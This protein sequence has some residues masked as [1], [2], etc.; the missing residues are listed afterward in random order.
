MSRIFLVCCLAVSLF[1]LTASAGEWTG[2][3]S[4]SHCGAKHMDGSDAAAKCVKSC[5]RGGAKL[6]FVTEDK[7]VI[8]IANPSAV[9]EAQYGRKVKVT[10]EMSG[11]S[12]TVNTID[13]AD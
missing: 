1:A 4:E 8:P 5:V 2:Y 3:I 13:L 9:K 12:L 6:S 11:D 10:G 7:K